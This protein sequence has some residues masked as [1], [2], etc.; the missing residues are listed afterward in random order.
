MRQLTAR[1]IGRSLLAAGASF[2]L[3]TGATVAASTYANHY[4]EKHIDKY[5][6][7][8]AGSKGS[9]KSALNAKIKDEESRLEFQVAMKPL[10]LSYGL[11]EKAGTQL[12][13]L[14][15]LQD[16]VPEEVKKIAE[17]QNKDT[18]RNMVG[19]V[20]RTD[21]HPVWYVQSYG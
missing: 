17:Q 1:R 14:I 2:A 19:N 7:Q 18:Q 16:Y 5:Y 10:D 8:E 15:V 6:I 9:E 13:K 11:E 4:F 20:T 21:N 12:A 3:G